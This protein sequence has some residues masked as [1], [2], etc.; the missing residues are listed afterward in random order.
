MSDLKNKQ[1]IDNLKNSSW[2]ELYVLTEHWTSDLEFYRDDLRFLHHLTEKYFMWISKSENLEV[3][4]E[5]K[6]GLFNLKVTVNDLLDKVREHRI[7]VGQMVENLNKVDAS[8]IQSHH[9]HLEEGI[10]EFVKSFRAN[11]KEVFKI[12]EYIIDSERLEQ[13]MDS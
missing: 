2:E 10:R 5:L 3:V 8:I 11:R 13:I 6:N 12:T 9:E 4:R 1:I 7:Q